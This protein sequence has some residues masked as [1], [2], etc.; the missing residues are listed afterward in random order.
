MN[1]GDKP[2]WIAMEY[3]IVIV[4]S[5]VNFYGSLELWNIVDVVET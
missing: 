3:G 1:I 4:M 5:L 2:S